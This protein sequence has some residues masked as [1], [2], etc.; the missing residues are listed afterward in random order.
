KKG[1][2]GKDDKDSD[3]ENQGHDQMAQGKKGKK[4]D[5]NKMNKE[6]AASWLSTLDENRKKYL[7]KQMQGRQ[8]YRVEKDW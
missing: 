1:S 6:E 2:A 8:R 4:G 7:K 3:K 5:E